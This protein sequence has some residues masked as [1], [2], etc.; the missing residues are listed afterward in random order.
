MKRLS[1]LELEIL[2][3]Y[4]FYGYDQKKIAKMLGVSQQLVS[5]KIV[6]TKQTLEILKKVW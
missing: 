5:K 1:E 6:K 4:A 3:L 2:T